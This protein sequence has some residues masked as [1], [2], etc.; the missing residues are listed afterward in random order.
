V[1]VETIRP[2]T[3]SQAQITGERGVALVK[4][5]VHAMGFLFTPYG[6]VEAGLDGLIEI[7]NPET[8]QVGAQLVAVQIK[9]TYSRSYT[10]ETEDS[11]EYLCKSEDVDYWQKGN[12]PIIVVLVRLSDSSLYWKPV[13]DQ[14]SP[15]DVETRRLRINKNADRFDERAG[16]AI[17]QI[18]VDQARPGVWV[19]PPALSRW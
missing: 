4:E 7:R 18:A 8:G 17:S 14:G 5:R 15:N 2:K 12:L 16:D 19:P 10:A 3:I 9:T 1:T 13:P 11:F 6:P